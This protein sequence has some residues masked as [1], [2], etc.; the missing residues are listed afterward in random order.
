MFPFKKEFVTKNWYF[1]DG[2]W[3]HYVPFYLNGKELTIEEAYEFEKKNF[4]ILYANK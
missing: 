4:D 2:E 1:I 3:V